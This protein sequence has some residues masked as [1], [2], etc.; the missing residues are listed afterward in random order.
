M[1]GN[2]LKK[3]LRKVQ[4]A[5]MLAMVT[6][7]DDVK[8]ELRLS[9]QNVTDLYRNRSYSNKEHA[10]KEAA[11]IAVL[12]LLLLKRTI[13]K[14]QTKAASLGSVVALN[15]LATIARFEG[16]S[17]LA[18]EAI[19]RARAIINATGQAI[20]EARRRRRTPK[21]TTA[22]S[23]GGPYR[24]P[25]VS[26]RRAQESEASIRDI[27]SIWKDRTIEGISKRDEI[28]A[29]PNSAANDATVSIEGRVAV[30][31]TTEIAAST[32]EGH[33]DAVQDIVKIAPRELVDA[34]IQRWDATLDNRTCDICEELDGSTI[35]ADDSWSTPP[36][37]VHPRCRCVSTLARR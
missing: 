18:D 8:E 10:K 13:P 6:L 3:E 12:L 37:S 29:P 33:A 32:A 20:E 5:G 26:L 1:N 4:R 36:G 15:E 35:P 22:E 7:E 30:T 16:Y 14:A 27:I 24:T 25:G 9:I 19:R 2:L 28:G 23:V 31:V 21:P 34:M 17:E 11:A